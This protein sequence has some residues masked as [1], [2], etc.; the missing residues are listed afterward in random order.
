MFQAVSVVAD[1]VTTRLATRAGGLE[2]NPLYSKTG[3]GFGL[4]ARLAVGTGVIWAL[5]N[6]H[7]SSPGLARR[8]AVFAIILNAVASGNN[9]IVAHAEW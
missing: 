7:R 6:L 4:A 5:N 1:V 2:R 8:L 9:A 3:S